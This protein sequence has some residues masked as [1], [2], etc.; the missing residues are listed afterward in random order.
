MKRDLVAAAAILAAIVVATLLVPHEEQRPAVATRASTDYRPGGYRAWYDV[1]AREGVDVVRFREHHEA[2]TRSGI[3]T[4]IVAFP[5]GPAQLDWD[6][7][8]ASALLDWVRAG[9]RMIDVG[10]TPPA[11]EDAESRRDV[12]LSEP[13]IL[14]RARGPAGA[15]RGPWASTV[16]TLAARGDLRIVTRKHA[17]AQV[18]A[19]LRDR[20]GALVVRY[21][22]GQGEIVGVAS[23]A[24]FQ[25]DALARGDDARLAYLLARPR[26]VHGV[27]AFDEAIRAD[28]LGRPWYRA[29]DVPELVALAFCAFAGLLWLA[30]G[31]VP[32]GPPH[33]LEPPREPTSAEF[34]D[35][36]AALYGRARSR[37]RARDALVAEGRRLLERAAPAPETEALRTRLSEAAS[38]VVADDR[39]LIAVAALAHAIRKETKT[40]MGIERTAARR[41]RRSSARI[42]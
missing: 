8:E 4:L 39:T 26:R 42:A 10:E 34:L 24:P 27:V 23:A 30:Y 31:I 12:M 17:R 33:R 29:L 20:A 40:T 16:G 19:L 2:L 9:G 14:D 35:A 15:L 1:A 13:V 5:E 11:G 21:R 3:D 18:Q 41:A 22:F 7:G 36:V 25:N 38:S 6:A 32:L 37:G 28:L